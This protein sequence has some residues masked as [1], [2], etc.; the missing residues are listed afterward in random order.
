MGNLLAALRR[1]A[2]SLQLPKRSPGCLSKA[3]S[4]CLEG[5]PFL[6]VFQSLIPEEVLPFLPPSLPPS[7]L[8]GCRWAGAQCRQPQC[9][10]PPGPKSCS[11]IPRTLDTG[12]HCLKVLFV[13]PVGQPSLFDHFYNFVIMGCN[14]LGCLNVRVITFHCFYPNPSKREGWGSKKISRE[15]SLC[16]SL[17]PFQGRLVQGLS[18]GMRNVGPW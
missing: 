18:L 8:L 11:S 3:H 2:D 16:P 10:L 1:L 17:L 13:S 6:S 5:L 12:T 9:G 4:S 7:Y 14:G 15:G